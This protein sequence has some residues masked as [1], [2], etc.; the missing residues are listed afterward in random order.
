MKKYA[1]PKLKFNNEAIASINEVMR[2]FLQ[3]IV[4]RCSNQASNEGL[5]TVNLGK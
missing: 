5:S 3:E 4:W 1:D 2:T